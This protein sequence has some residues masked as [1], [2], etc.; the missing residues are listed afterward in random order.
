[1]ASNSVEFLSHKPYVSSAY[2]STNDKEN[3]IKERLRRLEVAYATVAKYPA[4]LEEYVCAVK[5]DPK[6]FL[7]TNPDGIKHVEEEI[8]RRD[9]AQG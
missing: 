8:P 9:E 3:F 5:G 6:C 7:A 2:K 1:M 4:I